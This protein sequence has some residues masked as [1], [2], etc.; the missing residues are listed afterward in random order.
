MLIWK[1][2][3]FNPMAIKKAGIKARLMTGT[4]M[5][6][7]LFVLSLISTVLTQRVC[8]VGRIQKTMNISC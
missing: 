6:F 8:C 2:A 1:N 5:F 3:G 4:Y 7:N